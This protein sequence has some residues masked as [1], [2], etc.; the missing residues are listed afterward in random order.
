MFLMTKCFSSIHNIKRNVIK[1]I[2][3][4]HKERA[5][6]TK[7]LISILKKGKST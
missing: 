1:N 7:K 4:Y 5:I 6:L 3:K 2:A